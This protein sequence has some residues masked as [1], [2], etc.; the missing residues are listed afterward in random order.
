MSGACGMDGAVT[1]ACPRCGRD[2]RWGPV[3]VWRDGRPVGYWMEREAPVADGECRCRGDLDE[4]DALH[5]RAADA[6]GELVA[7][8]RNNGWPV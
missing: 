7:A 4:H 1:V 5:E 2:V 6:Y 8:G 3:I